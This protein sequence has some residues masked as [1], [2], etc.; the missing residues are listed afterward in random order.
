M[1]LWLRYDLRLGDQPALSYAAQQKKAVL[2]VFIYNPDNP[3]YV[4]VHSRQWLRQSLQALHED[5][6]ARGS[7]LVVRS[8]NYAS[9]LCELMHETSTG[10]V[11]WYESY[12]PYWKK[13]D[14]KVKDAIKQNGGSGLLFPP[15]SLLYKP[16]DIQTPSH[17]PYR[18]FS[19]YWNRAQKLQPR[20]VAQDLH[21]VDF[22][23]PP[24]PSSLDHRE[25]PYLPPL[26]SNKQLLTP[27]HTPGEQGAQQS[28]KGFFAHLCHYHQL[29]DYPKHQG[30]SQLST[31]LAFGEITPHQIRASLDH[32][33]HSEGKQ[34]YLR[35]LAWRE[36]A[37][38]LLH[39]FPHILT[40]PLDERYERMPYR[41]DPEELH[42]WQQGQTGY[43]IIDAAMKELL[44][45]GWMHGRMR[46]VVA[47]Y[48]CKNLLMDWRQG[49]SW[50]AQHLVDYS[51]A[52]NAMNWQW[53]AGCGVDAAPYFRVFN[54]TLQAK[55]FDPDASYIKTYLPQLRDF[56]TALLHDPFVTQK[57][58][59]KNTSPLLSSQQQKLWQR[60]YHTP[61]VSCS[62]TRLRALEAYKKHISSQ[63]RS[64]HTNA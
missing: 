30:T 40:L 49:A 61:Q 19:H 6:R 32:L 42:R 12:H 36:Y 51:P 17:A 18:V 55:K 60:V 7:G 10:E 41:T 26:S 44:Q 45:T 2:M 21:R 22:F 20:T 23:T 28:L 29:R 1:I 56:P 53:V 38:Y 15:A 63:N 33:L 5:L 48:F 35:E 58:V 27:N 16:S 11:I 62:Q 47:S 59:G 34:A 14:E 8:G 39:H 13:H 37:F 43:P 25:D 64:M 46:M 3:H 4:G 50:F 9:L 24:P 54:P 31:Y 57:A 52:Q